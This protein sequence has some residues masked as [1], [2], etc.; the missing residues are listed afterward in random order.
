[1]ILFNVIMILRFYDKKELEPSWILS[2]NLEFKK[3]PNLCDFV[4]KSLGAMF[5]V[6]VIWFEV[7]TRIVKYNGHF[8][9]DLIKESKL[10]QTP[11]CLHTFK[12]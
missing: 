7:E 11:S 6:L 5:K 10:Q 12:L 1:M 3:V 4:F 2:S 8:A 9:R